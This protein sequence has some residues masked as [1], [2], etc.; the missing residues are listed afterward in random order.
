MTMVHSVEVDRPRPDGF[1]RGFSGCVLSNN[2]LECPADGAGFS[3]CASSCGEAFS[4]PSGGVARRSVF[5]AT[6][7]PA[8]SPSRRAALAT[9]GIGFTKLGEPAALAASNGNSRGA[10][11]GPA[12]PERATPGDSAGGSLTIG[13]G[14]PTPDPP[15]EL[16]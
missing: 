1:A 12:C 13:R 8:G 16:G 2:R 14:T 3:C 7:F 10:A 5:E 4:G 15:G 9:P 6:G 11:S